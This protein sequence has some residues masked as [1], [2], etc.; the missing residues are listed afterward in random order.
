MV[1]LPGDRISNMSPPTICLAVLTVFEVAVVMLVRP[2]VQRWLR[3][4]RV[5]TTVVAGNGVMMTIFLWHLTAALL[6][7]AVLYHVG[8]P[9]PA[10]GSAMWWATRPLWIASA[11]LPLAALIAIFGRSDRPRPARY[12]AVGF[13]APAAIGIGTALLSVVVFGIACSDCADLIANKGIALA[14]V[15][16]TPL[17]LVVAAVVGGALIKYAARRAAV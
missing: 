14:V 3:R 7:I 15:P 2:Y 6:A 5:W 10:G 17:Q 1:G 8:F 16:V 12:R 9:Q 4:E 11:A 13:E